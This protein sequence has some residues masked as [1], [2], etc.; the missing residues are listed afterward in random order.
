MLTP[1]DKS[2]L[3]QWLA[4]KSLKVLW[5]AALFAVLSPNNADAQVV[6]KK[7]VK[8]S[9]EQMIKTQEN[10]FNEWVGYIEGEPVREFFTKEIA[11]YKADDK[12]FDSKVLK[13]SES[14]DPVLQKKEIVD[15]ALK[16]AMILFKKDLENWVI[17]FNKHIADEKSV[18]AVKGGKSDRW[19]GY[20]HGSHGYVSD[21][22]F[23]EDNVKAFG[24]K[25]AEK[26]WGEYNKFLNSTFKQF[27]TGAEWFRNS[28]KPDYS[29][30]LATQTAATYKEVED[31]TRTLLEGIYDGINTQ[32]FSTKNHVP[33]KK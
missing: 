8:K 16:E 23:F 26:K 7:D 24:K 13:S 14:K 15:K 28:D 6:S 3:S 20:G 4:F 32:V 17:G 22:S 11:K 27:K 30:W 19:Y 25:W 9:H 2:D 18:Y 12:I 21:V 5:L 10:Y 1:K 33:K 31:H 29:K